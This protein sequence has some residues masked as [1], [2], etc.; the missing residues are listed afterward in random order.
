MFVE[1]QLILISI[2]CLLL[3]SIFNNK[4]IKTILSVFLTFFLIFEIISYYLTDELIDY[5]FFIHTDI[6]SIKVFYFQFKKEILFL[7]FL[8]IITNYIIIKVDLKKILSFKKS[9]YFLLIF[10]FLSISLPNKSAIN[11]L[12]EINKIYNKNLFYDISELN[13]KKSKEYEDFVKK[14]NL[15]YLIINENL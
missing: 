10:V 14:N 2:F 6:S 15:N 1:A 11:K 8:I 12:Y 3:T 5:R 4:I 13:N 9:Y 7:I